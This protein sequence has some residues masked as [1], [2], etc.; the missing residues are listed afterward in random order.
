MHLGNLEHLVEAVA[1]VVWG[2]GWGE[3]NQCEGVRFGR[4]EMVPP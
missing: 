1:A 4:D 3:S 2:A